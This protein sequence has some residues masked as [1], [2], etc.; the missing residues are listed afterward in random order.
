VYDIIW[1]NR[2]VSP[3]SY[4]QPTPP[5]MSQCECRNP[6]RKRNISNS[7]VMIRQLQNQQ[8]NT[9]G[10]NIFYYSYQD[11]KN[12]TCLSTSAAKKIIL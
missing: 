1:N 4:N 6:Q 12:A 5:E 8:F 11:N 3:N 10:I 9:V 2:E 7:I